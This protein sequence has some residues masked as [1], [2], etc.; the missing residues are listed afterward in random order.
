MPDRTFDGLLD[1]LDAASAQDTAD[2]ADG[3]SEARCP[4][5]GR[6]DC[7][8]KSSWAAFECD[9]DA[10]DDAGDEWPCDDYK[11]P[12]TCFT[13]PKPKTL[14][15]EGCRAAFPDGPEVAAL[16]AT[17]TDP[18]D[19]LSEDERETLLSPCEC[20]HTIN[21]HGSLATCWACGDE[22][23]DACCRF[24]FE[25]L[26]VERVAVIVSAR[27]RPTAPP[28]DR[29]TAALAE[30]ERR[31]NDVRR[32]FDTDLSNPL[33]AEAAALRTGAMSALDD[34]LSIISAVREDNG[35]AGDA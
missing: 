25:D 31:I 9:G 12:L 16:Y 21:D 11:P 28:E 26:L 3:L 27:Q 22:G 4:G 13:T 7:P 10:N 20:G 33:T 6:I 18:A 30:V 32:L 17:T 2:P 14:I 5:C 35:G 8:R 24:H 34:C 29:V 23:R 15:C 1:A 19:G